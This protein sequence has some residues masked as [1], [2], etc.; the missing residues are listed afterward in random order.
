MGRPGH[1][2][3]RRGHT[4][5]E[6]LEPAIDTQDLRFNVALACGIAV[7]RA[8]DVDDQFLGNTEIAA[9]I[10]VPKHHEMMTEDGLI[11]GKVPSKTPTSSTFAI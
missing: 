10:A 1:S 11:A 9:R 3:T 4:K 7:L 8:F 5:G 6:V 2:R